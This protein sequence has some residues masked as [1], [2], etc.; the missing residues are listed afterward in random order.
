MR[1]IR[2]LRIDQARESTFP[3]FLAAISHAGIVRYQVD[4]AARTAAYNGCHGRAYI[5]AYLWRL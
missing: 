1:L 4:F 5:E 3:E 2:A